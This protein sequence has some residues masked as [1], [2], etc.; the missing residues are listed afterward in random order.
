MSGAPGIVFVITENNLREGGRL[1]DPLDAYLNVD[2]NKAAYLG[3]ATMQ[4]V[5]DEGWEF[6][7]RASGD[8]FKNFRSR[9]L[10]ALGTWIKYRCKAQ[11]GD[12][13]HARWWDDTPGGVLGLTYVQKYALPE[14][15]GANVQIRRLERETEDALAARLVA[16]GVPVLRQ[17][18]VATGV[19]DVLTPDT[20]YEVKTWLTRDSVFEGLGQLM[21]YQAGRGDGAPLRLVL[22]GRETRETAPMIPVLAGLGVEV[23]LWTE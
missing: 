23:E 6:K 19:I 9:P 8:H 10:T 7:A 4:C 21:V 5:T 1:R 16:H 3:Q 20:L 22:Y 11:P 15:D 14:K 2:S 13:I 17:V 18:R 12:E